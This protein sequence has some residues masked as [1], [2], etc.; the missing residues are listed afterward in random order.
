MVDGSFNGK[1]GQRDRV[2]MMTLQAVCWM[3]M[4]FVRVC[5]SV[6]VSV[7]QEGGEGRH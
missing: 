4:L 2:W 1:K 5:Q 6:R 7:C 3:V